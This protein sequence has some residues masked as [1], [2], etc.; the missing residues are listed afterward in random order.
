M[1]ER[2]NRARCVKCGDIIISRH[3]HDFVTCKCGA[4]SIDGGNDYCRVCAKD[5][6]DVQFFINRK[7]T[8]D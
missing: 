4:I 7:W 2:L 1:T 3:R 6:R 8:S 5:L